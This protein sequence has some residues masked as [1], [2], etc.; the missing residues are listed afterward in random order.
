MKA[1]YLATYLP[2]LGSEELM[3]LSEDIKQTGQKEPIVTLRDDTTDWKDA[4]LDGRNRYAACLLAGVKPKIRKF[5]S[6]KTDGKDPRAFVISAN[7]HRR[8][9]TDTQRALAAGEM[10]AGSERGR[11]KAQDAEKGAQDGGGEAAG[12]SVATQAEAAE[13]F[14]VPQP[15]VKKAA[16]LAKSGSKELKAAVNKGEVSLSKAAS[17]AKLPKSDQLKAAKS[18][19]K[20]KAGKKEPK[21]S[22]KDKLLVALDQLWIDNRDKWNETPMCQPAAMVRHFQKLIEKVL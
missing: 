22:P 14:D 18:K 5:G 19:A 6:E 17:V 21:Q 11:P 12:S 9:L 15:T 10:A 13:M 2:E 7:I 20:P 1:H 4:I 8:H 16:K 3:E